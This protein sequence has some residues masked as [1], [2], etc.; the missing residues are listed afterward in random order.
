M[1]LWR[2]IQG[3][4]GA[5]MIP[6]VFA[7]AYT[8]FPRSK[9][10]YRRSDHRPGRDAGADHRPDGRRHHHRLDVVAL[11]VLHQHRPR[12]RHHRRRA[13]AGRFRSAELR[14]ARPFRLVGPAR[15][16]RAFS[17]R[18]NM[19]SRKG[20]NM[21]GCRIPRWRSAPRSASSPRIAFFWRVLTARRADR[22]YQDLHR[23]QFR[24]RL[25]DLVLHRHRPLRPDLHLSALSRRGARLQRADD[26]RDHVRL[27]HHHVPHRADR[28]PPDDQVRH[29]LHHRR[30]AWSS[31]RS[32]PT[33]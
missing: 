30:R 20:R 29:A 7:S 28:R 11:A 33:R 3:F 2:A 23:P 27:R 31:S 1:I 17:A 32:A 9:F 14:A 4:L 8:V 25:P 24:H 13:R 26:R 5:G 18:S 21:S 16:W 15:S 12:H 19:C 6:T 10:S 22:R